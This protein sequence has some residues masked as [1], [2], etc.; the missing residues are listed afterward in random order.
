[1]PQYWVIDAIDECLKFSELFAPLKGERPCFPLR[2][3]VT[4][5]DPTPVETIRSNSHSGA[6]TSRQYHGRH[7]E[8]HC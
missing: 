7:K 8:L 4:S 6:N 5:R 2:I 3:F 1:M